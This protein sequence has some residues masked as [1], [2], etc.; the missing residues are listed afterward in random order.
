M[1]NRA[2][3]R[4]EL[5]VGSDAGTTRGLEASPSSTG[6]LDTTA[7]AFE[8]VL[9]S[10]ASIEAQLDASERR[11]SVAQPPPRPDP[12]PPYSD[13]ARQRPILT[14]ATAVSSQS[15]PDPPYLEWQRRREDSGRQS[16]VLTQ[17]TT[18][19]SRSPLGFGSGISSHGPVSTG[20]LGGSAWDH[21]GVSAGMTHGRQT[22]VW[23]NP[24]HKMDTR[25]RRHVPASENAWDR[26]EEGPYSDLQRF[27]H[28]R[29]DQP[30]FYHYHGRQPTAWD[31]PTHRLEN[32]SG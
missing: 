6:A 15:D 16:A 31:N 12:K 28:G 1:A 3:I 8:H 19:S 23:D 27:D 26:R 7:L 30:R 11:Y 5:I 24:A 14:T 18:V 2:G 21:Y 10:L 17:A 20:V 22:T 25:A 4:A 29:L 13:W 32:R 9:A